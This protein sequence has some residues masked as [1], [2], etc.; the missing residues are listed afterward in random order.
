MSILSKLKL[1]DQTR[2]KSIADPI[3]RKREKLIQN[4]ERQIKAVE[5]HSKGEEY[6]YKAERHIRNVETGDRT[7]QSVSV[8]L[9]HWFWKDMSGTY[10]LIIKYGNKR[11]ELVGKQSIEVGEQK[12]LIPTLNSL[13]EA[14]KSGELDTIIAGA[15]RFGQKKT[16]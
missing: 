8:R 7:R 6:Y 13:V 12:N 3:V 16:K 2:A 5:A 14:V 4:I 1:S 9:K 15:A 11:L 10:F